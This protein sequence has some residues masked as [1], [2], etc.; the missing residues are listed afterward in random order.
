MC[1]LVT[2]IANRNKANRR[3]KKTGRYKIPRAQIKT[4]NTSFVYKEAEILFQTEWPCVVCNYTK[5]SAS[6]VLTKAV[7]GRQLS[8]QCD[9]L[10]CRVVI[11]R[12]HLWPHYSADELRN[13]ILIRPQPWYERGS[14]DTVSLAPEE[15]INAVLTFEDW[16]YLD[17]VGH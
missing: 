12:Q 2:N 4:L 1:N 17:V 8:R 10:R 16:N 14:G 9:Q 7:R 5:V 11:V 15:F 6:F 13:F 3:E